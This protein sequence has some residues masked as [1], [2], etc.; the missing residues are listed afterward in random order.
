MGWLKIY[1]RHLKGVV[2]FELIPDIY[3]LGRGIHKNYGI[4]HVNSTSGDVN[5]DA[6]IC[7]IS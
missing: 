6:V 4:G 5:H 2:K 1:G 7:Y 3:C